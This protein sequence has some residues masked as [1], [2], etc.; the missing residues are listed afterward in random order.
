MTEPAHTSEDNT[1]TGIA[2]RRSNH[3]VWLGPLVAFVGVISYFLIFARFPSLRD[4]P[5]VNLPI[6]VAG[7]LMSVV[8]L[9][10]A[11]D[12]TRKM[13]AKLFGGIGFLLSLFL[14]LLFGAYIFY[15]SYQLPETG[16]VVQV[17][18]AAPDFVLPDQDEQTVQLS[19]CRG[20]KVVLVF[21]RGHW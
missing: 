2:P 12:V 19:D 18:Q 1:K 8:G 3:F 15:I 7:L 10:R 5:W 9:R 11:F 13:R 6:V 21:Y 17:S 16:G 14:A 20:K 4:F